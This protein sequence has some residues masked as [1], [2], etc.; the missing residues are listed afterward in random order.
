[1]EKARLEFEL[2]IGSAVQDLLAKTGVKP[3]QI[4]VLIANC[5]LFTPTP[6]LCAT[7][8]NKLKMRHDVISYNL[9][10]MGCSGERR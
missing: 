3:K 8:M 2:V 6:S 10:G 9:G 1:M 5:S 7:L 4:G